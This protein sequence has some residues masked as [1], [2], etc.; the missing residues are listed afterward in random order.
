QRLNW[1]EKHFKLVI[2]DGYLLLKI[3]ASK[4]ASMIQNFMADLPRAIEY[5]DKCTEFL[6]TEEYTKNFNNSDI[7]IKKN[8]TQ[9][10]A[11]QAQIAANNGD[12]NK[13]RELVDKTLNLDPNEIDTVILRHKI[14]ERDPKI[15]QS[16]KIQMNGIILR[17]TQKIRNELEQQI[18]NSVGVSSYLACNQVAWLLANTN[19][20]FTL[21]KDLIEITMKYEPD[22]S[23]Y[24]DTQAHVFALGKQ[25]DKAIEIQTRAIKLSPET[26]VY[27]NALE[28]FKKLKNENTQ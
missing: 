17:A 11:Y 14:C 4:Y 16:Y 1:A 8:E 5:L 26:K 9:K 10:L 21:A 3:E 6:K 13:A 7:Q 22:S 28:K 24:L 20:D 18:R 25:F 2:D 15:E 23:T 19:G 12:W 27:R